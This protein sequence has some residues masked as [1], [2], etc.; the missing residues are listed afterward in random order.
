MFYS[1]VT[2]KVRSKRLYFYQGAKN[3]SLIYPLPHQ[4][5]RFGRYSEAAAVPAATAVAA[6]AATESTDPGRTAAGRGGAATVP[7]SRGSS[8]DLDH[9]V[10]M[11]KGMRGGVY[12]GS[13]WGGWE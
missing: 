6:A 12:V 4:S 8:P 3:H 13:L 11:G 5:Q 1:T 2:V 10:A 9:L 7:Q